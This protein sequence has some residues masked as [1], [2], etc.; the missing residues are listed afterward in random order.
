MTLS[1]SLNVFYMVMCFLCV[2]HSIFEKLNNMVCN[3]VSLINVCIYILMVG[4]AVG[5][6]SNSYRFNTFPEAYLDFS[7]QTMEV[8]SQIS[9]WLK[10]WYANRSQ[11]ENDE[12]KLSKK[13]LHGHLRPEQNLYQA[14][15][16]VPTNSHI[17]PN[18]K[19]SKK[20]ENS[21]K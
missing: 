18:S 3:C 10:T 9:K 5:I 8:S 13:L 12:T 17:Q 14:Q 2:S 6:S 11:E 4:N 21:M 1:W 7:S 16:P 19:N 15:V 20:V